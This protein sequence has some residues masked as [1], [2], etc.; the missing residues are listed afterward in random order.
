MPYNIYL[1]ITDISFNFISSESFW[2]TKGCKVKE[3]NRDSTVCEC[4]HLTHFGILFDST[5]GSSAQV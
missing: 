4:Y 5:G 1:Q 2:S 3:K